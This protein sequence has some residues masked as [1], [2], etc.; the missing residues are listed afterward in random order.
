M[1][2]IVNVLGILYGLT[3]ILAAFVRNR[4]LEAMR[5]DALVIPNPTEKTRPVNLVIGL[6]IAGYAIY[7]LVAG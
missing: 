6:L 7:S 1:D 2:T 5:V 4:V 3:L